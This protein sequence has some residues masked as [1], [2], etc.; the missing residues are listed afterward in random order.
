MVSACLDTNRSLWERFFSTAP[1]ILLSSLYI[2]FN[3]VNRLLSILRI[4]EFRKRIPANNAGLMGLIY[5]FQL[6][7]TGC[8]SWQSCISTEEVEIC[9]V[10]KN[11]YKMHTQTQ[12][13]HLIFLYIYIYKYIKASTF[14]TILSMFVFK[15]K[16]PP[17]LAPHQ[18][19]LVM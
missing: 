18:M 4:P 3:F 9:V 17:V 7:K 10:W 16:S 6:S 11:S 14:R 8:H 5:Y 15:A 12:I 19:C 13:E 1:T 2:T